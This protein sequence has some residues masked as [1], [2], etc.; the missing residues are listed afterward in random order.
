MQR[1]PFIHD[2]RFT[3]RQFLGL[4]AAGMAGAGL[5]GSGLTAQGAQAAGTPKR[6]GVL[7][8]GQVGDVKSFDGPTIS[9]NN[10]IWTMLLLY[11]QLTRPTADGLSVEPGLAQSWDIS[12]DGKTYTF[13][14]RHGVTFHDGSPVTADDVKFSVERAVNIKGG[15]WSFLFLPAFK[16]MEVVDQYTVRAHLNIPHAPFL[17][18]VA[19]FATSVLPKKLVLS[20][21]EKFFDH[22]IGTGPFMFKS[23][24]KGSTIVMT[25]NP[26]SFRAPMPYV[27]EYHNIVVPDPN[28]RVLQVQNGELDIALF[29][30]PAQAGPLKSNPNLTL[31]QDDFFDSHFVVIQTQGKPYLRDKLVRQAM[32][33]AIDKDAI[34][35]HFLY[36]FGD[37]NGQ[38]LPKMFGYSNSVQPYPYDLAKAKALMAKSSFP[39]GFSTTLI[40]DASTAA[41]DKL[42]AEYIQQQLKQINIQVTIQ[43]LDDATALAKTT[44]PNYEMSIGYMTSDIVDPDEL[45]SFAVI[46]HGGT[47]AI[48][49]YYQNPQVDKLGKQA[50]AILDRGQRQRIYD[51]MNAIHHDDAPMIFLY[52]TPSLSLTTSKVQGFRVL[53]TGNYRLEQCWFSS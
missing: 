44:S 37:A 25:R 9:D 42:I 21:G 35:K 43:V 1:A 33:Y 3:R 5:L 13:H 48:W 18:D 46:P 45:M 47:D 36:G 52:R 7:R 40:V 51:Q 16:G 32:N 14:L 31:H 4:T 24:A 38:A 23:W 49:T 2:P 28:T 6:G 15:Q 17:S 53:P 11:D 27:D 39:K 50:E 19:L 26:N 34:V 41:P 30:P 12:P 22:P 10:S 8:L 20:M 29:V